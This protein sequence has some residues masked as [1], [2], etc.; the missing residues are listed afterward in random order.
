MLLWDAFPLSFPKDYLAREWDARSAYRREVNEWYAFL[1]ENRRPVEAL[2]DRA[3][4]LAERHKLVAVRPLAATPLVLKLRDEEVALEE[5]VMKKIPR[6]IDT[7]H[8]EGFLLLGLWWP[9]ADAGGG[10]GCGHVL[11]GG[12]GKASAHRPCPSSSWSCV[13]FRSV[14]APEEAMGRGVNLFVVLRRTRR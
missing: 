14:F 6:S 2:I 3:N 1:Y 5:Q 10:H 9:R 4:E 8:L 12:L 7:N 11:V 13:E